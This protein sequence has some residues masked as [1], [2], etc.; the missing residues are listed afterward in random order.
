M[1]SVGEDGST[2][3]GTSISRGKVVPLIS[4]Y[5]VGPLGLMHLPRLWLKALLHARDILAEDWGCGPGGLDKRILAFI[6]VDDSEFVAW[7]GTEFPTYA[8]CEAWVRANATTLHA[9]SI[10]T[11]N[12]LLETLGLPRDLGP[13]FRA[14][15]GL[16]DSVDVGIMLNNYDDW[17]TVYAHV[18][19]HA[20]SCEPVVPAVSPTTVGLLGSH[21]YR[22][23]G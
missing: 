11:S 3:H 6:G 2:Y 15:L 13:Q 10:A 21:S 16:D 18:C 23:T 19:E 4:S 20:D 5:V 8:E 7:L 17:D 1:I 14:H 9:D 22:V 12:R